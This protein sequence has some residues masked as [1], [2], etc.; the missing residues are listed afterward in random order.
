MLI[1]SGNKNDWE[2]K[3]LLRLEIG[4]IYRYVKLAAVFYTTLFKPFVFANSKFIFFLG[5]SIQG[6]SF[7][8]K[9]S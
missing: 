4:K 6:L 5:N 3:W 8:K 1:S 9:E 2:R 7:K